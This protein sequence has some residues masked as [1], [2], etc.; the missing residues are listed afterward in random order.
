MDTE[1]DDR[2]TG[3]PWGAGARGRRGVNSSTLARVFSG[4]MSEK[5]QRGS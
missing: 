1:A 4:M 2:F 3:N 5:G